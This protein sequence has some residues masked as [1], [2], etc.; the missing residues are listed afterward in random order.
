MI[1]NEGMS[2]KENQKNLLF[3]ALAQA[4]IDMEE[5]SAT[6]IAKEIVRADFSSL[7]A[8]EIGVSG[9]MEQVGLLYESGEYFIPDLLVCAEIAETAVSIL[10]E[11]APK[12]P[13]KK[14]CVVIGTVAGDTHDIGKNIVALFLEAAGY[15]V[16]DLGKDVSAQR[17]VE[18][19]VTHHAD[20]IA[21]S[22]LMTT[23]M[24]NIKDVIDLLVQENKRHL[25]TVIVGGKPLSEEFAKEIG[26]DGYAECA[27]GAV[28][29]VNKLLQIKSA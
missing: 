26:A 2:R 23:T 22:T 10:L 20:V 6:A 27:I 4:I 16:I 13:L 5:E 18:E 3:T 1:G 21:V 9:G 8:I 11:N 14:A 24:G 25:F 29:L 17:F 12:E 19:A 15:Q 7:S 28:R